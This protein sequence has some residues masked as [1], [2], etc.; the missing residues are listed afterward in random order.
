MLPLTKFLLITLFIACA[1]CA[2]GKPHAGANDTLPVLE[3]RQLTGFSSIRIQGPFD[4]Y[5]TQGAAESIKL[6]APAEITAD[7]I[8]EITGSELNVHNKHDKWW[9]WGEGNWLSE[10][11]WWHY[12]R[13]AVY[14][15]AKDLNGI[16]VSGS[17]HIFLTNGIT[18][19]GTF[20]LTIRGSGKSEGKIDATAFTGSISGSGNIT[21]TGHADD[22]HI[23]ISGSG[24][25]NGD[26]FVTANSSVHVS[27]SGHADVNA[28]NTVDAATSGSARVTYTGPATVINASRRGSGGITRR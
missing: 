23:H 5:V 25:F 8:T 24:S 28:S 15:T 17:G 4:V 19:A 7:I 16:A 14:I 1:G 18:A 3:P 21:I 11:S 26:Q 20:K 13:A 9:L 2:F 12:H 22:S 10:K 27:G 6:D